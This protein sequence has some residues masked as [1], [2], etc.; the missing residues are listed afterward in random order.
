MN[1]NIVCRLIEKPKCTV[2]EVCKINNVRNI[3]VCTA[4]RL[5][6]EQN[7]N[8][9]IAAK[10]PYLSKKIFKKDYNLQ[11]IIWIGHLKNGKKCFGVMSQNLICFR[12]MI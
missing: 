11:K 1:C 6:A 4:Q 5:L 7:L 8:D 10:K 12:V 2:L 3:S 9:C